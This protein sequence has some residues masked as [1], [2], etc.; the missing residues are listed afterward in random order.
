MAAA[1]SSDSRIINILGRGEVLVDLGCGSGELLDE[2]SGRFSVRIGIDAS[3]TRK[4]RRDVVP[5]GWEFRMSD[6]NLRFPFGDG[7]ADR[8]MANQVIEHVLDPGHFAE[9]I[10]RILKPGGIAVITTPNIRYIKHIWRLA[11]LGCGLRTGNS[12]TLDGNWDNGHIHYFTHSDLLRI[13]SNSGFS[14]VFSQ[15][16]IDLSNQSLLRR[17]LDRFSRSVPVREFFSGNIL[18]VATK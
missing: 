14:N 9:E 13:F 12:E 17:L 4:S 2:M 7:F 15:A 5:T 1:R 10:Y 18:L 6:L 11:V 8:V 16:H 3:E